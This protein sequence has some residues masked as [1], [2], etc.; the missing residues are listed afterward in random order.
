MKTVTLDYR[1]NKPNP[2]LFQAQQHKFDAVAEASLARMQ[3]RTSF[4][5]YEVVRTAT[6]LFDLL[7]QWDMRWG[8][9]VE[10]V[11]RCWG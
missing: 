11:E 6:V 1:R 5:R 3:P 8:Q 7:L 9:K 2:P 10:V 4:L